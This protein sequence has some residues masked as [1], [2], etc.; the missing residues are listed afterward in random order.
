MSNRPCNGVALDTFHVA[1]VVPTPGGHIA[2]ISFH[3][4]ALVLEITDIA[5]S[6]T[7]YELLFFA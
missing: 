4:R 2:L 5:S 1:P 3:R 6:I 7:K